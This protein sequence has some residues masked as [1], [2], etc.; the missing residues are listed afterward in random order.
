[1]NN[2]ERVDNNR[3]WIIKVNTITSRTAVN[4]QVRSKKD[5][6]LNFKMTTG[7]YSRYNRMHKT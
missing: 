4:R 1:M 2:E 7:F 3:T 5:F 6:L